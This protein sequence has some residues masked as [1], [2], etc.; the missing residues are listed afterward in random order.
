MERC[1]CT[2]FVVFIKISTVGSQDTMLTFPLTQILR[3]PYFRFLR[4]L[5]YFR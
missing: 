2:C 3:Y 5:I 1:T 4:L